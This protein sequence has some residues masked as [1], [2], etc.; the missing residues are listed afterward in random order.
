MCEIPLGGFFPLVQQMHRHD[1]NFV[2]YGFYSGLLLLPSLK[3]KLTVP[4]VM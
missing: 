1:V 4:P 3:L 2:S